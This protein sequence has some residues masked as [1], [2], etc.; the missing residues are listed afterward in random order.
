MITLVSFLQCLNVDWLIVV[1]EFGIVIDVKP[2]HENASR[3]ML[4]TELGIVIEVSEHP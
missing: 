1:M 3:S 2:E 4:S